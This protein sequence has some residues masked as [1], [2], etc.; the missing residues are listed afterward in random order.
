MNL[1]IL[2]TKHF[3]KEI[4]LDSVKSFEVYNCLENG[5]RHLTVSRPAGRNAR[6][7]PW[8]DLIDIRLSLWS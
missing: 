6:I 7:V 1:C 4:T 8:S 5:F 2:Y 3:V